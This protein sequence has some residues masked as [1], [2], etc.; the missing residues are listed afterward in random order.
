M[1]LPHNL[2]RTLNSAPRNVI[3]A[4]LLITAGTLHAMF[5]VPAAARADLEGMGQFAR[6]FPIVIGVTLVFYLLKL[7]VVFLILLGRNWAKIVFIAVCIL[8]IPG[9][10]RTLG[11]AHEAFNAGPVDGMSLVM[12][13]VIDYIAV[14]YLLTRPAREWFRNGGRTESA[15]ERESASGK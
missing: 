12:A 14:L 4:A 11:G 9:A 7:G 15:D 10:F 13:A 5:L 1:N 2:M 6:Y 8:G 3:F